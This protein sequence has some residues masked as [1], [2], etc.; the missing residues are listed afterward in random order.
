MDEPVNGPD[1]MRAA[2][3]KLFLAE[4]GGGK[5]PFLLSMP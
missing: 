5:F 4:N 3:G 2:N 1:G